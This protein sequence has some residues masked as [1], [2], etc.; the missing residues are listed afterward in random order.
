MTIVERIKIAREALKLDQPSFASSVGVAS[1]DT[2]SRWE[3]G[4]NYPPADVLAT[5]REKFG[6][7]VEWLVAGHGSMMVRE[8][9]TK[10]RSFEVRILVNIQEK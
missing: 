1:R 8:E 4:L 6:I 2:I 5:I 10:S 9:A 3:R 7:S